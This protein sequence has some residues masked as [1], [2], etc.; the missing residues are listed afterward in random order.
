MKVSV[1]FST[2]WEN[3]HL[4]MRCNNVN[5]VPCNNIIKPLLNCSSLCLIN[6]YS[7]TCPQLPLLESLGLLNPVYEASPCAYM[8]TATH[9]TPCTIAKAVSEISLDFYCQQYYTAAEPQIISYFCICCNKILPLFML[10]ES[11]LRRLWMDPKVALLPFGLL[12]PAGIQL[13]LPSL[14]WSKTHKESLSPQLAMT[15]CF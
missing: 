7:L 3:I 2:K 1:S 11:W 13:T 12:M 8:S 10:L 15:H 9:I 5:K 4:R 14:P 6:A